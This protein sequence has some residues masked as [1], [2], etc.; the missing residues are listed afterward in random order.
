[1]ND[2]ERERIRQTLLQIFT[3]R[4]IH[5]L[6]LK[7]YNAVCCQPNNYYTENNVILEKLGGVP[8][9]CTEVDNGD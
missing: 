5:V 9:L 7:M 2:F 6:Q 1:M 3:E 4:E 8:V